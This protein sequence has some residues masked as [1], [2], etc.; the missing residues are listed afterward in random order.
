MTGQLPSA[1][2]AVTLYSLSLESRQ[3]PRMQE[4]SSTKANERLLW[5]VAEMAVAQADSARLVMAEVAEGPHL[6]RAAGPL[7]TGLWEVAAT[8]AAVV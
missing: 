5:V 1:W 6:A 3:P 4:P 7:V 8:M 2:V